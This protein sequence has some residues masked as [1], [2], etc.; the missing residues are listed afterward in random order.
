M[1][2][3]KRSSEQILF[4]FLGIWTLINLIQASFV[5]VH[6]DEAYYWVY[7]R[8]LDWGYFDH[9]PMVALFIRIGDSVVQSTLGLRLLTVITSTASAYLLWKILSQ[10]AQNIKLFILLFGVIVL[11]HVYGFITSP[12]A[13]LFFFMV[14]FFYLYQRYVVADKLKW[15]LL[16][17]LVIAGMLYSK[18][19]G[20]LVLFFTILSN[21]KL[22]K[23][24]SFWL[25]VLIAMVAFIPHIWWQIQNNFP[26]FY[27]HVIDRSSAYYKLS[28][29]TEYILGQLALAGPLVGWYLY[30]SAI[31]VKNSDRFIAAVK[32][33]FYGIFLFF[34]I[35]TLKGRV[36]AHWTLPAMLCL[37]ML[38][39]IGMAK[40]QVPKW[41]N[42]L[43]IVNIGLVIL[44][45]LI[46][47]VPIPFLMKI[48]VV[49]YYFGTK[50][51]AAD[52]QQKAGDA[53]VIFVDSF[54]VPS[55]YNYYTRST[56]GFGYDSRYYRKNQ[57]DI[58]PL[59]DSI[60]N[61]KA[62][63]VQQDVVDGT[64]KV[65]TILTNKGLYYGCWIEKVRMYQKLSVNPLAVPVD[66]KK[67]ERRE[68][69][70]KITNP[71]ADTIHLGNAN[72]QWKCFLEYSFKKGPD[73]DQFRAV[74]ADLEDVIVKPGQSVILK[75][76]ITAPATAGKYKLVLSVRTE[77]FKGSRNSNMIAVEIQ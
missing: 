40:F 3:T 48:K 13:P 27:Y 10:Y 54:Q 66:W 64:F 20:V 30:R 16:L 19:H 31:L 32:F 42:T 34:L 52:I 18:Y 22:F 43:A 53:P 29:T 47:I 59:E 9:P 39:Y 67:G 49:D 57:Y 37:F 55:R 17:A 45:R 7:S 12:D 4:I 35:S 62:Y 26:S 60:R 51:W 50:E 69:Q 74:V 2:I 41:F 28:F 77:P 58:W 36:E 21:W 65:D 75:A 5:E 46:L 15:A 38:A 24:R 14:L 23:R 44:V 8:F 72:A 71:Y 1:T 70:L 68:L 63:F 73:L 6:A 61:R 76:Q 33:N 56:H 11:F 25:V